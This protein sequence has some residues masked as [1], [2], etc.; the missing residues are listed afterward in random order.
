MHLQFYL[1]AKPQVASPLLHNVQVKTRTRATPT[2]NLSELGREN[3]NRVAASPAQIREALVKDPGLLVALKRLMAKEATSNGQ[4]VDDS[5]LTDDAIFDRLGN[6][7]IFRSMATRLLQKYGY[8]LPAVNPDSEI[9][10]QQELILKERA[11]RLVQIE[12]QEDAESM[13]PPPPSN[14]DAQA[15]T[16]TRAA[17]NSIANKNCK[18]EE[19]GPGRQLTNPQEAPPANSDTTSWS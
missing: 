17:C 18:P 13:K 6:D 10:K 2:A 12:A 15:P 1:S 7:V 9:G 8:L 14:D 4:L 3:A 5:D 16:T 11:R 19:A